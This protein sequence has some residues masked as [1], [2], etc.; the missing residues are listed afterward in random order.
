MKDYNKDAE[1]LLI[2]AIPAP[3]VET[4]EKVLPPVLKPT[5][6][7]IQAPPGSST[8]E[9]NF[10]LGSFIATIIDESLSK[11]VVR[12]FLSLLLISC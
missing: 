4:E 1:K 3:V 12:F 10:D 9:L 7:P 11:D 5:K 8:E 2:S 6:A